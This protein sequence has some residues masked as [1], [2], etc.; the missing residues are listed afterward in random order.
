VFKWLEMQFEQDPR[1][2]ITYVSFRRNKFERFMQYCHSFRGKKLSSKILHHFLRATYCGRATIFIEKIAHTKWSV[3]FTSV[4][5][6]H[7]FVP[8]SVTR[9]ETK[10]AVL[11]TTIIRGIPRIRVG[12][13]TE[14]GFRQIGDSY[15][16]AL[17]HH[18]NGNFHDQ[19]PPRAERGVHETLMISRWF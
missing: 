17:N 10:A 6:H 5:I 13:K 18:K 2:F 1:Q 9:F 8:S 7:S 4:R 14:R 3:I 12:V 16:Q 15:H 11:K 19:F